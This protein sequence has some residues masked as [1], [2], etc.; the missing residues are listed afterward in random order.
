M[1][2]RFKLFTIDQTVNIQKV[3]T[4]SMLLGAWSEGT[5]N[6]ILDIGTGTGILA[7]MLAQRNPSAQLIA[8]E[9]DADSLNEA[10]LNFDRS[11]FKTQISGIQ[12]T[13]QH[14][15]STQ[16]FDLIISNPPY[17]EKSTLSQNADKN[18]ARHTAELPLPDLYQKVAEL[19]SPQGKLNLIFP[20]DMEAFHV[21][22][23]KK[24]HLFPQK[25]VRTV[26]EDGVFKRTL[27]SFAF[28]ATL[29]SEEQLLVKF[30][31]NTYS[32]EYIALT[33]DFYATDLAA[34]GH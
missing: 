11:I 29:E 10:V 4:D 25:I 32:P 6:T 1:H 13:L 9:P 5:F 31:D 3:G 19:L 28:D 18:R 20:Y 34:K 21:E 2:F 17:F 16:K 26:R 27:I 33:K 14:F 23:A 24:Q 12:T 22:E 15:Q 8:I 7:L 30:S